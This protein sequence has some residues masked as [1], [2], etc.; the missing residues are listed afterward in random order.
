MGYLET[1]MR[2]LDSGSALLARLQEL[3][4][5]GANDT[6]TDADA[7]AIN[8]EAEAI[9]DEFHRLMSTST[10]K[11]KNIFVDTAG[12]EYVSYGRP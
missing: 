8:A 10:Y 2:V 9:A 6:N 11:G 5:L 1:G 3:A 7:N 4:V 12:G